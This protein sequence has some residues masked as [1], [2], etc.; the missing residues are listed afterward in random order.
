MALITA[1]CNLKSKTELYLERGLDLLSNK[2]VV[3]FALSEEVI[4]EELGIIRDKKEGK[5]VLV[6]KMHESTRQ[7]GL[8]GHKI[9]L[10]ARIKQ[11]DGAFRVER[12][13]FTPVLIEV[14]GYK[15]LTTE[16][17]ME[18]NKIQK[19]S[20]RLMDAKNENKKNQGPVLTVFNLWTYND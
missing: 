17:R 4:I 13:D 16:F 15:Y 18:E 8:A 20:V 19:L 7:T 10:R 14:R 2:E 11:A 1:S 9:F 5:K 6:F 12:W 3:D